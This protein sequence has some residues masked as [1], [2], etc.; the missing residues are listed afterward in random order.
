MDADPQELD[1]LYPKKP[2]FLAALEEELSIEGLRGE[3]IGVLQGE[4]ALLKEGSST[5]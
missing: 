5:P 4:L 1:N 3:I 2:S